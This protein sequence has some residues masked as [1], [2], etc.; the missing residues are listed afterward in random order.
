MPSGVYVAFP[1]MCRCLKEPFLPGNG[2]NL[3]EEDKMS[4]YDRKLAI[5]EM[6][7]S[8]RNQL[9]RKIK[10]RLHQKTLEA[11]MWQ[12]LLKVE[13]LT[14]NGNIVWQGNPQLTGFHAKN[15][16]KRQT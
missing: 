6:P 15:T 11:R 16:E 8:I 12:E 14:I 3:L 5:L 1:D 13:S 9:L 4:G 7:E 2:L 10:K